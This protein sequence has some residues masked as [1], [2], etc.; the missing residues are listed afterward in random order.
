MRTEMSE[1]TN[2][3]RFQSAFAGSASARLCRSGA[4]LVLLALLITVSPGFAQNPPHPVFDATGFQQN[5]DYFSQLPFEHIDTLTGGLVL[6]FTDLMLPGN[7]G[8]ELRIQ[9]AYNS[10]GRA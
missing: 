6:T 10:K 8:R 2:T 9:R 3:S 7:A 4:R 5:R 1:Q